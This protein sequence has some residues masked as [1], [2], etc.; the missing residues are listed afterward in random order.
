MKGLILAGGNGT[1]LRPLKGPKQLVPIANRPNILYCLEDLREAGIK[2]IGVI[3]GHNMPERVMALLGNGRAFGTRITYIHQGEPK[4]IAHAVGCAEEFMDGESFVVY[5]G[6]NILKGGIRHM[7][8]DFEGSELEG[9]VALC[10]VADPQKFGVAELDPEGNIVSMVEKPKEP[11]SNLAMVG[12]YF[13]RSSIF[14]IIGELKPSW[15][16]ELEITDALDLLRKRTGKVGARQVRGWWKDTGKPEDILL[17]NRLVL[18]DLEGRN[19]GSVE[20][21]AT[22]LGRVKIGE[23][24]VIKRGSVIRGPVIV[25]K[26]CVIGP[27][28]YLGPYTAIGN[29]CK[30]HGGEIEGSI[31]VENISIDCGKRIVDSLVGSGCKIINAADQRRA[32]YRLVIG[33]NSQL[34]L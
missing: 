9:M 31:L 15:R 16:N 23:G 14:P 6:D 25:G 22:L 20:E 18:E 10:P 27:G 17:A 13:L 32:S 19:E 1:G 4:G 3:L 8:E 24:T 21:G 12:I 11:E 34:I 26:D 2:D 33:E 29:N 30:V 28:T 7:V 5:L